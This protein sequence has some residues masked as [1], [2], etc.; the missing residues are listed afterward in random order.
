MGWM[1]FPPFNF[2]DRPPPE[3]PN[4]EDLSNWCAHPGKSSPANEIAPG[5][6]TPPSMELRPCDCFFLVGTNYGGEGASTESWNAPVPDPVCD[7]WCDFDSCL[8]SAL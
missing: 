7:E 5:G 4:Y 6:L 2:G 3:A 1:D 8:A